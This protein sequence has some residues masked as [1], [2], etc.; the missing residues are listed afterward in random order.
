MKFWEASE[1]KTHEKES[2]YFLA[3]SWLLQSESKRNI[4]GQ[5]WPRK[6]DARNKV[7]CVCSSHIFN[8]VKYVLEIFYDE[9]PANA[10]KWTKQNLFPHAPIA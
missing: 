4:V 9:A 1:K 8:K 6:M 5:G 10:L 2:S 3:D 7:S